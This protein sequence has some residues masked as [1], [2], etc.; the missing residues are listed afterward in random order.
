MNEEKLLMSQKDSVIIYLIGFAVM[1]I[2]SLIIT[3]LM[4]SDTNFYIYL[5]FLL[6]QLGYIGGIIAYTKYAKID[7]SLNLKENAKNNKVKYLIAVLCGAG[8]FFSALLLNY[9]LEKLYTVL[10]LEVSVTVPKL[11]T[12][13]DYV[14]SVIL[15]CIVPPIGEELMF[16][17][18]MIDGFG[19]LG[20][21]IAV[22][23]SGALFSLSHLN[24]AQTV[25]QF[26]LGCILA[27][28][29]IKTKDIIITIIIHLV[30]NFLA[31]FLSALTDATIWGNINVLLICFGVGL[32]VTISCVYFILSNSRKN[33]KKQ[34]NISIYT[35]ILLVAMLILWLIIAFI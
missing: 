5:C 15:I 34:E 32:L 27:L 35:I 4:Q 10:N 6:P 25:Y 9:F 18:T 21:V 19:K 24:I 26:I 12:V 17:K 28:I 22:L 30:N 1:L 11:N 14:L 16:R 2:G 3:T 29:Y 23:L 8:I 7:F 20:I 31:F 33:T 13:W